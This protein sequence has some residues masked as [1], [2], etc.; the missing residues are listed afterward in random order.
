M[1]KNSVT[2]LKGVGKQREKLLAEMGI[3][4]ISDLLYHLP[5]GYLDYSKFTPI[6]E[7]QNGETV[8]VKGTVISDVRN[9]R[10]GKLNIYKF[11]VTDTG[12]SFGSPR[13]SV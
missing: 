5:R 13:L 11:E 3:F 9:I 6:A 8:L 4:T 10:K 1:E 12:D 7:I 2:L